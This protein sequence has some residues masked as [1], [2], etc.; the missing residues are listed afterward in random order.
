MTFAP[1]IALLRRCDHYIG[2]SRPGYH[3]N[4]ARES[5]NGL[6]APRGLGMLA[7]NYMMMQSVTDSELDHLCWLDASAQAINR[8]ADGHRLAGD[9]NAM[10]VLR[11]WRP[12]ATGFA[13]F[14]GLT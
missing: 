14:R 3:W 5:W 11:W 7:H 6:I 2:T 1:I 13:D 12:Q 9:A 8:Y 10:R 4:R